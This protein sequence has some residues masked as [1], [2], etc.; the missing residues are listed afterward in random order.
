V[1]IQGPKLFGSTQSI[2]A[3]LLLVVGLAKMMGHFQDVL[4]QRALPLQQILP[5]CADSQVGPEPVVGF[6]GTVQP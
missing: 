3:Q 6:Q 2:A 4:L 1:G 5:Y